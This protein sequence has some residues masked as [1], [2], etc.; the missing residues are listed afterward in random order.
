MALSMT[1]LHVDELGMTCIAVEV[2][3]DSNHRGILLGCVSTV[4]FNDT[5]NDML[6]PLVLSWKYGW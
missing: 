3:V 2:S 5:P 1:P 6:G 4:H